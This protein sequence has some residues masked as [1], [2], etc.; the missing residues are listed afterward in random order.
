MTDCVFCKIVAGELPSSKLWE[1]EKTLA[2]LDL[3]PL[4]RGHTLVIP[5]AHVET[6][7]EA[8]PDQLRGLAAVMPRLAR[9]VKQATGAG[10]LNLLQCNGK[11]SGQEVPH[12]HFHLIPRN[13]N[14]GLGFIWRAKRYA[15]D[16]MD[17]VQRQ[18]KD[19]LASREPE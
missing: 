18:I 6:V 11:A 13:P 16:E 5:K 12:L 8:S 14:D 3:N 9:A 15:E 10:G 2:F 7:F 19:A 1:D 4:A 17:E